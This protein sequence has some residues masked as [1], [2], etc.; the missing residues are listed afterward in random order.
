MADLDTA[1][2]RNAYALLVGSGRADPLRLEARGALLL[3]LDESDGEYPL[4]SLTGDSD[5]PAS[6]MKALALAAAAVNALP[7]LLDAAGE[8]D[9]LNSQLV[10]TTVELGKM[11]DLFGTQFQESMG[12]ADQLV[13]TGAARDRARDSAAALLRLLNDVAGNGSCRNCDAYEE[14]EAGLARLDPLRVNANGGG[15]RG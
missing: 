2:L 14:I 6:D 3:L 8:R 1:A 4:A 5:D 10:A 9:R 12:L 11:R 15:D 13:E 7:A